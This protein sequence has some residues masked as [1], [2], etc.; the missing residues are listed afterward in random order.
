[1]TCISTHYFVRPPKFSSGASTYCPKHI[2][3]LHACK[4]MHWYPILLPPASTL[5]VTP[6]Y[7]PSTLVPHPIALA[8]ASTLFGY[9]APSHIGAPSYC[10][11]TYIGPHLIAP[12]TLVPHSIALNCLATVAVRFWGPDT[13]RKP[14]LISRVDV[15]VH[16]YFTIHFVSEQC[17]N[18]GSIQMTCR[19]VKNGTACDSFVSN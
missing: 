12:S 6:S 17:F 5:F 15:K 11:S 1:M 16:T 3:F 2:L 19:F 10:S 4:H 18:S 9:I 7:C 14:C 8:H 13:R